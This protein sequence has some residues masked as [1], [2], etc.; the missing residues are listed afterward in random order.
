MEAKVARADDSA[1]FTKRAEE[2]RKRA[3]ASSDLAAAKVHMKL[4]AAYESRIADPMRTIAPISD[5]PPA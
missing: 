5:G 2:E 4:A 3:E 1:Y